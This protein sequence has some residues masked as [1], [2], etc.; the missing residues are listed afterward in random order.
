MNEPEDTIYLLHILDA[1]AKLKRYLT[2]IEQAAFMREQN[3]LA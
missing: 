2:G 1:I 3:S